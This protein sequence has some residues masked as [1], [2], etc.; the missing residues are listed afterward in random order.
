MHNLN[1][2]VIY[3]AAI[4]LSCAF[5]LLLFTMVKQRSILSKLVVLEVITNLLMAAIALWSLETRHIVYIDICLT[6]ALM[7]FLG[8][9]AYY[10]YLKMRD[11]AHV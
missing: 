9:V 2:I 8:I 5:V 4:I 7:M 10:Q 6:I 3:I 1:I 11:L